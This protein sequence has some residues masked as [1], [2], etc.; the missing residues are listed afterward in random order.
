M[1][2]IKHSDNALDVIVGEMYNIEASMLKYIDGKELKEAVK[3]YPRVDIDDVSRTFKTVIGYIYVHGVN[4][5]VFESELRNRLSY[6]E[7]HCFPKNH[8][9]GL[10]TTEVSM[11]TSLKVN[12]QLTG[13]L[14][15]SARHA[16]VMRAFA[17]HPLPRR[18]AQFT[19]VLRDITTIETTID[20]HNLEEA[21]YQHICSIF[22]D[23]HD[24]CKL[25]HNATTFTFSQADLRSSDYIVPNVRP[26]SIVRFGCPIAV[27]LNEYWLRQ[28]PHRLVFRE[29]K[30]QIYHGDLADFELMPVKVAI[31]DDQ[32]ITSTEVCSKCRCLLYDDNYVLAGSV[33]SDNDKR[34]IA[35]CPICMHTMPTEIERNYRYIFRVK[36]GRSID[37][38]ISCYPHKPN[39][40]VLTAAKSG[41]T[42]IGKYG[43]SNETTYHSIGDKYIGVTDIE[44]A[45]YE[46]FVHKLGKPIVPIVRL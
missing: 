13:T 18:E 6:F 11:H 10:Y 25:P 2:I 31:E 36:F 44:K 4:L 41:V 39:H 34:G 15:S 23:F 26:I 42:M 33:Y 27:E 14:S 8:L 43:V 37:Q 19:W 35:L 3:G 20:K 29:I 5:D 17:R 38:V 46:P 21:I 32:T 28:P 40:D 45:R 16:L 12:L 7:S 30:K 24:I 1:R 22:Y 9:K